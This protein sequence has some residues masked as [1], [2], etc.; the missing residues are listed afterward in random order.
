MG[1]LAGLLAV[2]TTSFLCPEGIWMLVLAWAVSFNLASPNVSSVELAG[3]AGEE[4]VK[5]AHLE[6]PDEYTLFT[7]ASV[8]RPLGGV[9]V[10]RGIKARITPLVSLSRNN[11]R[12]WIS[13]I[14]VRVVKPHGLSAAILGHKGR[15][16]GDE[17]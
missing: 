16:S 12:G 8:R 14:K 9:F 15:L 17:M 11:C 1:L 3:A 10:G 6:L 2:V 13:S 7:G 4:R 5:T